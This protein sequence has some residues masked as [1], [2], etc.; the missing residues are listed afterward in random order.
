MRLRSTDERYGALAQGLHWSSALLVIAQVILGLAMTRIDGGDNTTMYRLHVGNGLLITV[1]TI[2]RALWRFAEPS[3][4]APPMPPWRRIAFAGNH[5]ALYVGL[6]ALAASGIATLVANDLTPL[7]IDLVASDVDDVRA[8]SAH[9]VLALI[10][11]GL[12]VMHVGGVV[13]YQRTK[14]NVLE[15]M[16]LDLAGPKAETSKPGGAA[17]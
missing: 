17:G 2:G 13:S 7:P 1:L 5:Y 16:G 6:F 12:V 8:G 11:I 9:F 14:G 15:K 10:Y 3:P 4:H